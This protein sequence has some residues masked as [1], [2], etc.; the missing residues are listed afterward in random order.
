MNLL[1]ERTKIEFIIGNSAV[2]NDGDA[3]IIQILF[4]NY[5]CDEITS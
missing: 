2:L 1:K 4:F 5:E 3:I